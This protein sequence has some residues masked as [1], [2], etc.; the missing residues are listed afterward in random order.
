MGGGGVTEESAKRDFPLLGL[1]YEGSGLSGNLP[2]IDA[3]SGIEFEALI[4]QLL[5]RMG[6]QVQMTKAS[7][8]GGIDI[9]AVLAKPIVG[10]RYVI[11][12]K[13]LATGS[14]VSAPV[15]REFYG[16][17]T[18]DRE[19]IK[20]LLITTSGFTAQAR[21]F[22]DG[23]RL[24]LIDGDHLRNLLSENGIASGPVRGSLF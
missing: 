8:D 24:E 12:C 13:R 1:R 3:L 11:Q 6:F 14:F 10:G 16:A 23:L 9:I 5:Q 22:A 7:G 4:G 17:L 18:A 2:S 19:A 21:D 15:V 20:G